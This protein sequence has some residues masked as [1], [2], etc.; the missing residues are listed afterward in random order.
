MA[1]IRRLKM[2]MTSFFR[3]GR[4][5]L[6]KTVQTGAEWHVDCGDR[7]KSKPEVEF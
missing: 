5:D 3:R 2:D 7:S 6:D 4:S 1:E